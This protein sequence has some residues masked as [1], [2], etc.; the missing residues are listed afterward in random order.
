MRFYWRYGQIPVPRR[1][2]EDPYL[3]PYPPKYHPYLGPYGCA[4]TGFPRGFT[5]ESAMCTGICIHRWDHLWE[6]RWAHMAV[7]T[8]GFPEDL[9]G[10]QLCAQHLVHTAGRALGAHMGCAPVYTLLIHPRNHLGFSMCTGTCAHT[11][12]PM[13]EHLGTAICAYTAVHKGIYPCIHGYLA[14][15]TGTWPNTGIPMVERL[16]TAPM[17]HSRV[18]TA[19]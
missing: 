19:I 12:I 14:V 4:H 6:P 1:S 13:V 9:L 7:C 10:I 11:G 2:Q 5:G 18:Y 8:L 17:L 15:C 3:G 16:C